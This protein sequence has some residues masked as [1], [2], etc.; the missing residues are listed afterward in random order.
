MNRRKL[1]S[2]LG[3]APVVAVTA[4]K[5]VGVVEDGWTPF[6]PSAVNDSA[7]QLMGVHWPE[8]IEILGSGGTLGPM[9]ILQ[10]EQM[11]N[12]SNGQS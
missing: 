3:I 5:G 10:A 7:R 1:L 2:F 8:S 12:S 11:V 9:K 4:V 6:P